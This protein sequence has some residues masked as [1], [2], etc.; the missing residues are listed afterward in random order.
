MKHLNTYLFASLSLYLALLVLPAA[1]AATTFRETVC[2]RTLNKK[3]LD[4]NTVRFWGFTKDCRGMSNGQVPGPQIDIN[5]D[6]TLSLTLN[7]AMAPQEDAPYNGH[8]IHMHGADVTTPNDGV[9]DTNGGRVNGDTYL[10]TPTANMPGSY[11]YHCH[12]HT[13]KHLEMGMYAPLIVHRIN[14]DGTRS[15]QL[16]DNPQ[17]AFA[18][19]QT[20][21]FSTVDPAYH[22]AE[23]DSTVFADYN[24]IYFLING[25]EG[26]TT[27]KPAVTKA[28]AVNSK[29]ALRLIGAQAV[30]STFRIK[31]GA[32][33]I[34]FTVYIEDGRALLTPEQVTS[35][36]INPGQRYDILLTTPFAPGAWYPQI[37]YKSL[38]ENGPDYET[39]YGEILFN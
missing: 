30:S 20:Y 32:T 23:G 6:D 24:P 12:V 26:K 3:M 37:T 13:V 27:S 14:P 22:T 34:P 15:N 9:P 28:V 17:T 19:E 8:T 33:D 5:V 25:N 29:V 16:T 7:M 18:A 36:D 38:R 2:V 35:L 10:W 21:L 31:N 11:M 39:V 4:G 1:Q